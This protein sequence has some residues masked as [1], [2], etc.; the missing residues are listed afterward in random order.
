MS[1]AKQCDRCGNFYSIFDGKWDFNKDYWRYDIVKD[2][3]P[4][5]AYKIDLCDDCRKALFMW[6]KLEGKRDADSN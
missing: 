3:H 1:S 2:C 6:L 5:E 4:N